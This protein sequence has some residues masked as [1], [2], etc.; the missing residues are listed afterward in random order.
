MSKINFDLERNEM[1]ISHMFN[2]VYDCIKNLICG[3]FSDL[4]DGR[5]VKVRRS[6]KLEMFR[7]ELMFNTTAQSLSV[8]KLCSDIKDYINTGG[9]RGVFA[10]SVEW[11]VHDNKCTIAEL[12]IDI[13]IEEFYREILE[14]LEHLDVMLEA[15]EQSIRHEIGHLID[16]IHRDGID[17]VSMNIL[18][19]SD[20]NALNEHIKKYPGCSKTYSELIEA[21]RD[22]FNLPAESR[23]NAN[24]GLTVEDFVDMQNRIAYNGGDFK[25][26]LKL[27]S[28]TE[29]F[30]NKEEDKKDAD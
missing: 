29:L 5:P 23:A 1:V 30:D 9:V 19:E 11:E 8:D 20:T 3:E 10:A 24:V 25:I 2:Y 15:F 28:E 26:R 4:F 22:Y 6:T 16:Y 17:P 13:V 21:Y 18:N 27:D 14:N 7:N 12:I